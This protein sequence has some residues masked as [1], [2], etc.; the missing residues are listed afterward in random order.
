MSTDIDTLTLLNCDSENGTNGIILGGSETG[1]STLLMTILKNINDLYP[2]RFDIIILMTESSGADPYKKL[3]DN[4]IVFNMFLPELIK[5]LVKINKET[6]KRYGVLIILDD[7]R[8]VKS[9]VLDSLF[10]IYRNQNVSAIS[11]VQD[12]KDLVPAA[13]NSSHTLLFTG[14][15][16]PEGVQRTIDL[17]LKDALCEQGYTTKQEQRDYFNRFTKISDKDRL[18]LH[19]Q[20]DSKLKIYK[21]K[22][23]T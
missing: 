6:D 22:K 23:P 10:C 4:V 20:K 16:N 14:C 19:K 7:I 5:L 15:R 13:R 1:K 3:P 2:K 9:K 8:R 21:I 11:L 12:P 17:F 18:V